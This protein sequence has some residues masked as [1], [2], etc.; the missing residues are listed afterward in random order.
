MEYSAGRDRYSRWTSDYKSVI[1]KRKAQKGEQ[2]PDSLKIP[3]VFII[4]ILGSDLLGSV[5]SWTPKAG[6]N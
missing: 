2:P 5:G 1:G 4:S 6:V 3:A